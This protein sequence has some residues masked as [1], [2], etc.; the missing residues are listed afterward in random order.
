MIS[1]VLEYCSD[2][3]IRKYFYT[4][5]NAIASQGNYDNREL[6]QTF[7]SLSQEKA[8]LLG[9]KN[10]GEMHLSNTMVKHPKK[11][12]EFL[13]KIAKAAKQKAEKEISFLQKTY[14]L[15]HLEQSD[16]AY[17][18]RKYKQD[19]YHIDEEKLKEYFEFEQVLSYL[20]HF[21]KDAF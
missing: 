19:H 4:R 11:A 20:H 21:V 2:P 13:E 3:Q 10:A 6:I 7:F 15:D 5:K 14:H 9:Y 8:H 1:A 18:K 12:K 17:Y 16:L